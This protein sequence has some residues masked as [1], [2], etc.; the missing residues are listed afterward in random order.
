MQS[1]VLMLERFYKWLAPLIYLPNINPFV[2]ILKS[3]VF[4]WAFIFSLRPGLKLPK[5]YKYFLIY[6]TVSAGI[7]VAQGSGLN[8]LYVSRRTRPSRSC[9]AHCSAPSR[10]QLGVLVHQRRWF[11]YTMALSPCSCA[12][13]TA[14]VKGSAPSRGGGGFSPAAR[15]IRQRCQYDR[16]AFSAQVQSRKDNCRKN[17]A[18]N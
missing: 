10:V 17:L 9:T 1:L 11:M 14:R 18:P 7:M 5:A 3:E 4:P 15:L 6:L 16:G 2:S 12:F 13:A 8:T